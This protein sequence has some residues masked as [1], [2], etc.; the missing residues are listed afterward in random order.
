MRTKP[1]TPMLAPE[2]GAVWSK[3]T[4]NKERTHPVIVT[5]V[6]LFYREFST[7]RLLGTGVDR[8]VLFLSS[9]NLHSFVSVRNRLSHTG[10]V[11]GYKAG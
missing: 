11:L 1:V 4:K 2:K 6:H 5:H 9:S 10:T 8:R 3:F 7:L